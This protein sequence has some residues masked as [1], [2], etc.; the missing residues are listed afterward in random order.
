MKFSALKNF[1][2]FGILG[3]NTLTW[4]NYFSIAIIF[5]IFYLSMKLY[6]FRYY[7]NYL[8][9]EIGLDYLFNSI[10]IILVYIKIFFL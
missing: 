4:K 3:Y 6:L 7:I 8:G 9:P 5:S 2:F 1:T 10:F